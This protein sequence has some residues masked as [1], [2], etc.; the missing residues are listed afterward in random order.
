MHLFDSFAHDPR[1]DLSFDRTISEAVHPSQKAWH[2]N[3][4]IFASQP[5]MPL[6]LTLLA[7]KNLL[8]SAQ[9]SICFKELTDAINILKLHVDSDS[10]DIVDLLDFSLN[11]RSLQEA[12]TPHMVHVIFYYHI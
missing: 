9:G 5:Y 6:E 1:N 12:T 10:M 4:W 3:L 8:R 11:S 2:Q 7:L